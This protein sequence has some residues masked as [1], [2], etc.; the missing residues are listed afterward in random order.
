MTK[1]ETCFNSGEF[2]SGNFAFMPLELSE[3]NIVE[4]HDHEHGHN[5]IFFSGETRVR[6]EDPSCGCR[7]EKIFEALDHCWIP[8]G[9]KHELV[10]ITPKSKAMCVFIKEEFEG[11]IQKEDNGWDEGI[12]NIE[13]PEEERYKPQN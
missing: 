10:A 6:T 4:S 1:L 2:T 7:R 5:I 3:G 11:V 13:K 9:V 8:A 12:F